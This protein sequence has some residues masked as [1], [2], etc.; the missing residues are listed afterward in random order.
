MVV[1]KE[2][3]G[4]MLKLHLDRIITVTDPWV[5]FFGK[6]RGTPVPIWRLEWIPSEYVKEWNICNRQR[7][8][9]TVGIVS[10]VTQRVKQDVPLNYF[11]RFYSRA[12]GPVVANRCRLLWDMDQPYG[13][14]EERQCS[15]NR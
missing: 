13:E 15:L 2:T 11:W 14:V 9:G 6:P 3:K 12:G 4:L 1:F 7:A 8:D 5:P 10:E